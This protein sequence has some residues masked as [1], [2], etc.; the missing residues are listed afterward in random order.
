MVTVSS[1]HCGESLKMGRDTKM[2]GNEK[3]CEE[4]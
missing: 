4:G 2:K 3:S 1:V